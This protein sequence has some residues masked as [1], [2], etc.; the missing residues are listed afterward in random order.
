MKYIA[1]VNEKEYVIEIDRDDEIVVNGEKYEMDFQ[2]LTEGGI[3]SLLLNNRSL[4]GLVDEQEDHM[5][6]LILGG[7]YEVKVQDERVYRLMQARGEAGGVTG[8]VIVASPMPGVVIATPAVE[9]AQV[10]KGDKVIVLES[11][12]MENELRSP[13]DGVVHRVHVKAGASVE[14]GQP[15]VTVGDE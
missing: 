1:T 6:V 2:E 3:L 13:R 4:E 14:K 7:L 9:G 11:M 15:L 8:D 5:E 12:K 10:K